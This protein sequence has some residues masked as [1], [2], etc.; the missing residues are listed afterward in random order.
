MAHPA[1][2][3]ALRYSAFGAL[4][5]R[6]VLHLVLGRESL[7]EH[8]ALCT[9]L[10]CRAFRAAVF[11]ARP[12]PRSSART[13]RR[14]R[15]RR[16]TTGV[17][18]LSMSASRLAWA[19]ALP[20][21][22]PPWLVHPIWDTSVCM[23]LAAVGSV[24][25][26]QW[27]RARG[28]AW[29]EETCRAA[30]KRG[31]LEVLKWAHANGCHGN[32]YLLPYAAAAGGHTEVLDWAMAQV[33]GARRW[34]YRWNGDM[35]CVAAQCGH[36]GVLKWAKACRARPENH[37]SWNGLAIGHR[38]CEAAAKYGR[39]DVLKW[40]RVQ[41]CPFNRD[42]LGYSEGTCEEAADGGHLKVMQWARAH[43]CEW[44]YEWCM[45][46]AQSKNH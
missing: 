11:E 44:D 42:T 40:L 5:A 45:E 3:E 2:S 13:P 17:R 27:A 38:V 8:D 1:V 9:A 24:V 22:A 20:S 37:G 6:G 23:K 18:S 21:M 25:G 43:G 4:E 10:A 36:L 29:N 12:R 31:H 33:D 26:L 32:K 14:L 7:L 15:P 30:A 28:C 39:L 35:V 41:G 46:I 16:L 19:H 34:G